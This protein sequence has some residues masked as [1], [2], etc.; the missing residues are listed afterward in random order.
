MFWGRVQWAKADSYSLIKTRTANLRVWWVEG[1]LPPDVYVG[2]MVCGAGRIKTWDGGNKW[3]IVDAVPL[4]K[5]QASLR[6]F[7]RSIDKTAAN[8]VDWIPDLLDR[9]RR[10]RLTAGRDNS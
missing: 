10:R 1:I 8:P 9:I 2:R 4:T 7:R 3:A 5:G 6:Y